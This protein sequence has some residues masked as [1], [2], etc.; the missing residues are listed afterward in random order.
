MLYLI[1]FPKARICLDR[2]P[3]PMEAQIHEIYY[4][5]A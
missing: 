4:I 1:Y 3:N 5:H 2:V